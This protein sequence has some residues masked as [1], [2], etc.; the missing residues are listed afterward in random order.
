MRSNSPRAGRGR[1]LFQA[2]RS[3]LGEWAAD[4]SVLGVLH[5][6]SKARGYVDELSDDDLEVVLT[7]KAYARLG[8]LDCF[9]YR[10]GGP[11][12][13]RRQ[14]YDAHYISPAVLARKARSPHDLDHWPY[15]QAV[16]L[17]DRDGSVA[18]S[19]HR[20]RRMAP[21]FR[22]RRLLHASVDAWLAVARA[23]KM[24][25]RGGPPVAKRLV[26]ARGAKAVARLIYGLD[27]RWV[28]FDYSLESELRGLGDSTGAA[29]TLVHAVARDSAELLGEA[30]DRLEDRLREEGVPRS[31]GRFDLFCKLLHHSGWR[32][33][34]VLGLFY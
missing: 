10:F 17:H 16:V 26:I 15:E 33:R 12:G 27:W 2:T 25:R 21:G 4:T 30:L 3:R 6:G 20:V 13:A 28:P 1:G 7:P 19:V 23:R 24:E 34:E 8:K 22:E 32:E 14:V 31:W 29:K 5:V 18:R 9:E 11:R